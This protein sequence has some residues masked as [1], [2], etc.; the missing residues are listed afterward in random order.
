M[1]PGVRW[2]NRNKIVYIGRLKE[3][4]AREQRTG[5]GGSERQRAEEREPSTDGGGS[6]RQRAEERD[7]S[8]P[9]VI[10]VAEKLN[11]ASVSSLKRRRFGFAPYRTRTWPVPKPYR[12]FFFLAENGYAGGTHAAV[13]RQYPHPRGTQYGYGGVFAVPVLPSVT[14]RGINIHQHEIA[15]KRSKVFLMWVFC[16]ELMNNNTT[17]PC[18][19]RMP[20]MGKQRHK[21]KVRDQ[22]Q[23]NWVQS[24]CS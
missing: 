1:W 8:L 23:Q 4:R 13:P 6:E 20:K 11:R 5:G 17:G 10:G 16:V 12:K 24:R 19:S 14:N 22:R 7:P 2:D 3:L 18:R 9:A 15:Q 21:H